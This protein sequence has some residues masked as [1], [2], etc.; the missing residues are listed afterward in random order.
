MPTNLPS[1]YYKIEELFREAQTNEERI[2]YLEEMMAIVPK[3]K[4]TDHLRADLKRKLAKLKDTSETKK[5]SSRQDSP[6]H[7]DREGAGQVVLI[8]PAN[9][10]KSAMLTALTNATPNV[11][12]Y[13]F[14]T[15]T[16]TPGMMEVGN[17]Q[18][19]LIDTPSLDREYIEGEM[20]NLFHRADL[21][22]LVVDL[23]AFPIEQIETSIAFLEARRIAPLSRKAH[24]AGQPGFTFIPLLVAVNKC[25][26]EVGDGDFEVLCELLEGEDWPMVP[27]SATSGRKADQLKQAVF[28]QL[29]IVRIYAKPPGKDP[30]FSQPFVMK[31]GGTVVEFAGKVHRDFLDSLKSARVWGSAAHD[32]LLVSRDHVL[33]DGDVVELH[34]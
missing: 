6:Y 1:D 16:P 21:L 34:I 30:D 10:G 29:D 2:R 8:G 18:I 26:D 11:A 23:Q 33:Q 15:W 9:T 4:G 32:G 3:H 7:I 22:L 13:P 27:I 28:D 24:Y 19:Q 25:D 17:V 20:I 14:T 12:E 5:S 31:K